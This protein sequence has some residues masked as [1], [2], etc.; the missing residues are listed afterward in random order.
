[1]RA[2]EPDLFDED[3]FGDDDHE[4]TPEELALLKALDE[5]ELERAM[6]AAIG[7][8]TG[9]NV[10]PARSAICSLR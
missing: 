7:V 5:A 8:P 4:P 9:G 6:G 1:M 10:S 3:P 2:D